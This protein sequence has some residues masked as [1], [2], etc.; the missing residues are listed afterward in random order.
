[1]KKPVSGLLSKLSKAKRR[2]AYSLAAGAAA[3][4]ATSEQSA[5]AEV[6][7]SGLQNIN[8]VPSIDPPYPDPYRL[9]LDLDG[10]GFTD[11]AL[12]N[13]FFGGVPYQ[14]LTITTFPG[15]VVGFRAGAF[16]YAYVQ[17]LSE[18][19]LIDS[20][21]VG[22]TF[23]GSMASPTNPNS[24][25]NSAPDAYLGF[26]FPI[27]GSTHFGWMRVG[28]DNVNASFLVKDWAYESESG[29]G[30]HAGEVPEPTTLG[31]LAAGA[32]GVALLRRRKQ[33]V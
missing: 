13:A 29:V 17:N 22:P 11:M 5:E 14:G 33:S 4:A 7:Y 10:D 3:V 21:T 20:T 18:G 19:A 23:F 2:V 12:Q 16:N 1:M 25:F 8:N 9:F 24:Q 31:L 6:V 15:Q 27:S 32:A 28:I 30:I 26:S